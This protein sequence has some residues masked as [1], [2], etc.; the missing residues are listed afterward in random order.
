MVLDNMICLSTGSGEMGAGAGAGHTGKSL[1]LGGKDRFPG[2][3]I[4][5]ASFSKAW[6][7]TRK[8]A[9]LKIILFTFFFFWLC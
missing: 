4:R 1:E 8:A 3:R 6:G 2:L 5:T 9:F 7:W